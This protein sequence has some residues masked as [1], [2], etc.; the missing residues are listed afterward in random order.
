MG[1]HRGQNSASGDIGWRHVAPTDTITFRDVAGERPISTGN[2]K[3]PQQDSN[4]RSRL[5]RP[6]L[7]PLSYGGY[8][9]SKGY[10][11]KSPPGHA[12]AQGAITRQKTLPS[13]E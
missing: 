5:R 4:L 9:P 2:E 3:R 12:V 7:S 11:P 6:L 8:A 1:T 13:R 10:Q